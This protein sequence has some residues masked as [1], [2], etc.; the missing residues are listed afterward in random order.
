MFTRPRDPRDRFFS[1]TLAPLLILNCTCQVGSPFPSK[2][3]QPTRKTPSWLFC[4]PNTMLSVF[5]TFAFDT[6]TSF[7]SC[8]GSLWSQSEGEEGRI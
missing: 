4:T 2:G 5:L 8:L 6:S 3:R 7:L 1:A